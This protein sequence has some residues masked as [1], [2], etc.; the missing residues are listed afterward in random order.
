MA[1]TF[2]LAA[3]NAARYLNSRPELPARNW[4]IMP[5]SGGVSN[6]VLLAEGGED[7]LVLKQALPVLRVQ[8]HWP[9]DTS[10]IRREWSAMRL[11]GPYLPP[12]ALP[13]ILFTD[14]N[15]F[16]FAMSAAPAGART[17]K[18]LLLEGV[19]DLRVAARIAAMLARIFQASWGVPYW[20]T[21]FGDLRAFD[22]LRL[23]P[24]YRFTA[25]RY[26][27]LSRHF[28]ECIQQACRLRF[29][30]VHGD[31]SPK[32]F[33]LSDEAIMAIDFEVVHYG[34]P[35]FD[36]AFLLNHL[37]LKSLY[38]PQWAPQYA[39]AAAEFW[40]VLIEQLP[41]GSE[42]FESAAIRHLGC[43]L[44][45]RIDGKSPVEYIR[46][47]A[48]KRRVRDYA[49]RLIVQPPPAM[50]EVFRAVHE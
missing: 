45:A 22:Q 1:G 7:R 10:R 5:L 19:I 28:D 46:D 2:E 25:H 30:L 39:A 14:E 43:L 16:I 23:D 17:W 4:R 48:L 50:A 20:E 31:W 49:R 15:N 6:I 44:L 8:E 24:Y 11:L 33:L 34:D 38:R 27:D 9:A 32:N 35:S 36:A 41:A 13:T 3:D 12:G 26:P 42:T 47:E 37:L 21:A 18:S 40:R 29:C